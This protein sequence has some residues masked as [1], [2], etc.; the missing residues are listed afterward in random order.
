MTTHSSILAWRIPWAEETCGLQSM[1]S[2]RV[3]RNGV[4]ST[5]TFTLYTLLMLCIKYISNEHRE[6]CSMI[7]GG[8]EMG[9][10]SEEVDICIHIADS[11][12]HTVKTSMTL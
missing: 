12:C 6:L 3:R 1:E 5:F 9:R 4:T 10:K 2:Q 7:S 8:K 11:L